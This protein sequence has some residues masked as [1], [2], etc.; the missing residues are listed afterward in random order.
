MPFGVLALGGVLIVGTIG[1]HSIE[2]WS[3]GEAAY[4]SLLIISTLGFEALHPN[5]PAGKL[6]TSFL[7]VAGVG[8]LFYLLSN[9]AEVLIE[10][11]LGVTKVRA[12]DRRIARLEKHCIICGYG[13]VGRQVAHELARQN[14]PFLVV[15]S[16]E[17]AIADAHAAGW[18]AIQGDA[19]RDEVLQRGGID[20]GDVLLVTT[21]SDATNVFITLTAR[22]YNESMSIVARS[23]EQGS[24]TKLEKAGANHVIAPEILGGQRMAGLALRPSATEAVETLLHS[25]DNQNWLEQATVPPDAP[26]IGCTLSELKLEDRTGVRVIAIHRED[27][28][29]V[30]NPQGDATIQV[31]DVL[32]AVGTRPNFGKLES[33]IRTTRHQ[34]D[35]AE[36]TGNMEEGAVT[37]V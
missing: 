7:I 27:D 21:G 10:T 23:N 13:R 24:E 5:T 1:Y 31:G 22:M 12:M 14:H 16:D 11:S 15:D 37:K 17:A 35:G 25:E 29:M 28:S 6:L 2:G 30:T 20:R 26:V 36:A 33:F 4:V 34:S 9:L 8:T 32:V 19:T 3:F 18:A